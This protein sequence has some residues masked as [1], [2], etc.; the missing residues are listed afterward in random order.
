VRGLAPVLGAPQTGYT[1]TV[2]EV[3]SVSDEG[4]SIG[5]PGASC[6]QDVLC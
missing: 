5:A 1:S 2:T 6:G 4:V 3:V